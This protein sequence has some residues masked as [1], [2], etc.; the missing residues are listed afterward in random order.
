MKRPYCIADYRQLVVNEVSQVVVIRFRIEIRPGVLSGSFIYYV[1]N[2]S[3][4][5]E[6]LR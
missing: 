1:R 3:E 4:F 5:G 6:Q 2:G